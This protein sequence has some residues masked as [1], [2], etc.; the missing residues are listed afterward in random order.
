MEN[1]RNNVTSH[2]AD[3]PSNTLQQDTPHT[4]HLT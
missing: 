4:L 2:L 1:K 3:H